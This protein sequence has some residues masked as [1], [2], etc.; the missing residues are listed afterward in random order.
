M[1]KVWTDEEKDLIRKY[2]GT[3]SNKQRSLRKCSVALS[4]S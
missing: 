2:K 4:I 1:G 3:R